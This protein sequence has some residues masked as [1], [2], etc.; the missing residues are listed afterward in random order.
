ML[1]KV[2]AFWHHSYTTDRKAFYLEM[3]ASICVVSTTFAIAWMA[4]HPPMEYIYPISFVGAVFSILAY[5]R[6]QLAWP[7]LLTCY[8]ACIHVFGFGRALTWW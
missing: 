2:K 1:N 5:W 3:M 8:F 7:F 4:Y 6:R